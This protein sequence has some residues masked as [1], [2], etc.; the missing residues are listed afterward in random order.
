MLAGVPPASSRALDTLSRAIT[1]VGVGALLA[2]SA[3]PAQAPSPASKTEFA[4]PPPERAPPPS[5]ELAETSPSPPPAPISSPPP[6]SP[7]APVTKAICGRTK[8]QPV[9]TVRWAHGSGNAQCDALETHWASENI[10]HADRACRAGDD[11]TVISSDGN[12]IQLPLTKTAAKRREYQ[13]PPCGNPMSGACPG[14]RNAAK[15][16]N[17]CCV[18]R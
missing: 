17:G 4:P 1:S 2:C 18:A 8:G 3:A 6:P 12:C 7:S 16:E 10:P 14:G 5:L 11:C 13:T 15:C 9:Q